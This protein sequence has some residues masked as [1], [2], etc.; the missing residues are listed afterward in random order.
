MSEPSEAPGELPLPGDDC[1]LPVTR[2][3]RN[4]ACFAIFW[5]FFYLAAPVSY[6]G[7]THANLL[8][9]LGNN[10]TF[11]NRPSAV[12]SWMAVVPVLT[13]WFLP[14]PR[15]LKP[16]ALSAIGG[17][18]TITAAVAVTLASGASSTAASRMVVAH[19]A[20]F[21]ASSGILLTALWDML[22]RGVST[23]RRGKAL[24]AAFGIG[25]LFACVGALLQDALFDGRLLGGHSFGLAFPSNYMAMFAAVAPLLVGLGI[26]IASFTLPAVGCSQLSAPAVGQESPLSELTSGLR[27]FVRNRSVLFAVV[28]YVIVYSGG[29]AIFS[30]V[31]LHAKEILG[32]QTDT[33]GVQ[34]FL[35]FGFKA[36]AGAG[37][38][39]LL[40]TASPRA[41][42]ITTTSILLVGMGWALGSSGTWFL[43]TFGIMGAGE[44]FGAYFPNYVTTASEKP[45]VRLN[46]AYLSLLSVLVGFSSHAFGEISDHFGRK[47]SFAVAAGM[48]VVAL[49]LIGRLLPSDP[50]PREGS[51]ANANA[52]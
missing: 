20:V 37:L 38:G 26:M 21:G 10:D 49:F 28:I 14:Q 23:S 32:Q 39:W 43:L 11:C 17:M 25:P 6:I 18:A 29:N 8:K 27:Q 52:G 45:F 41:T 33:L 19:A 48:L 16:L 22:R 34:T 46:M 1:P 36:A 4:I 7:L 35:R 30:N 24:G 40:A 51:P 44:L 12:Y 15:Y 47:T 13:A 2:Q 31:S 42:L 9:D 5:A 3:N 50:T